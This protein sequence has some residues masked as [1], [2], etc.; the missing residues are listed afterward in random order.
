MKKVLEIIVIASLMLFII[1]ASV[2]IRL[3][4]YN[5]PKEKPEE[6]IS[7]EEVINIVNN[8]VQKKKWITLTENDKITLAFESETDN[9]SEVKQYLKDNKPAIFYV[10]GGPF[11]AKMEGKYIICNGFDNKGN[12]KIYYDT[13]NYQEEYKYTFEGLIEFTERVLMFEI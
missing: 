10:Y 11:D 7:E 5:T 4:I 12:A 2:A 8:T 13:D 3:N 6:E 9:I 1:L